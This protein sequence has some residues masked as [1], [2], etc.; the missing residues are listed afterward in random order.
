VQTVTTDLTKAQAAASKLSL[1]CGSDGPESQ[2]PAMYHVLTG[3]KLAWPTG[4][5]AAHTPVAG[6]F[7]GVDFRPGSLS[8]VVE[9]TDVDWHGTGH[10]PYSFTAP[11]MPELK[12]AFNDHNA[13]FVDITNGAWTASEEQANEL[14]DATKSNIATSAFGTSCAVG[15]CCTGMS[16]AARA[17]TGPGG[18]CRLNFLHN[19]GAGVSDSIVTAIQ[20][21][22]VGSF[23]DVK[24]AYSNDPANPDSV[25]ATQFIKALRAM[26]E[27][28]T[29]NGCGPSPAKDTDADGVDDTFTAV[30][31]GTPVC[32]EII[33]KRNDTVKPKPSA[34]FFNAFV[35]VLGMPGA[36][37]L[38]RRTIV[39]LVPPKFGT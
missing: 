28:D 30:K 5:V 27:G 9:I 39:F 7:G 12:K 11:D 1:H 16:G 21:L 4:S 29:A 13:K 33:P 32:F 8:V 14:S 24:A 25:D 37:K 19:N 18:S 2:I 22:A 36:V 35:D 10:T 23:F 26:K 38:D 20:A 3:E 6:T 15:Q 31:V 34:Q 17:A